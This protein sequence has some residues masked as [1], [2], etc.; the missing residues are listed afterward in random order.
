MKKTCLSLILVFA[1]AGGAFA[2][3]EEPS[4][5]QNT[6][7]IDIVPLYLGAVFGMFGQLIEDSDINIASFGI[8]AQ[9]DRQISLYTSLGARVSFFWI[10]LNQSSPSDASFGAS[11]LS[12]EGNIRY[13]PAGRVFF[14]GGFLGYG[15]ILYL[16]TGYDD[17]SDRQ[18]V[19]VLTNYF[20]FGPRMGWR[21]DFGKPGGFILDIAMGY[22]G[23]VLMG[24]STG[25]QI[26]DQLG[27]ND[28]GSLIFLYEAFYIVGGPRFMLSLGWRF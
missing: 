22:D 11:T 16:G 23:A 27:Y 19:N 1:I 10:G 24:K 3:G 20:K 28:L 2:Q 7:L 6:V 18:S 26:E 8:A 4:Y 14:I 12:I 13:F 9:Y 17:E 15:N 5:P 25:R 21:I